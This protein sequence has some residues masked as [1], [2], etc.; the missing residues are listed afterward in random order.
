MGRSKAAH[1]RV[2]LPPLETR[3]VDWTGDMRDSRK[4]AEG[5]LD[6]LTLP[7][8]MSAVAY[9]PG[10]GY[11]A[12]GT[13]AG[14]VHLF[15]APSVR[16][17]IPLRPPLRVKH[18]LFKSDTYLLVCIDEKDNLSIYDLSRKDPHAAAMQGSSRSMSSSDLPLR[19]AIHSARN[20]VLCAEVTS[21]HSHLFLG[22][23]DGTVEVYDL[24]RLTTAPYRIPNLW[25][26]EEEIL[27][28]S[29]V[30]NA[31]SRLHIPL[32]IDI[33]THPRDLNLLLLCYEGGAVLY[34]LR[35]AS[36]LHSY[37][38]RLLPGA[39]GPCADDPLEV[40]WSERLCPATSMAWHPDGEMFALG[41]ENGVIS[42]WRVK[43]E[44]K[45]IMVRTLDTTDIERPVPPDETP[46]RSLGPREPIFKLTWSGFPAQGWYEYGAQAAS[47]WTGTGAA[48]TKVEGSEAVQTAAGGTVLTVM[49]G[50]AASQSSACLTV[51]HLPPVPTA[52]LFGSSMGETVTRQRQ[53][54]HDALVSEQVAVY[55]TSSTVEDYCLVPK[56]NPHYH[57]TFDPYAV[58][59]MVGADPSLPAIAAQSTHR[60][61]E[62]YSFPPQK[63]TGTYDRLSL[64]LPLSF[65]GRGTVLG[66]RISN[67]PL[68]QY[69]RLTHH[70]A[71][72]AVGSIKASE[73]MG[74]IARP[75][76]KG[77]GPQHALPIARLGRPRILVTWHLDG[78][79]RFHDVS[80]HLLLLGVDDA[81]RGTLLQTPF[82]MPLP[83]LT[84]RVRQCIMHPTMIGTPAL[85]PLQRFPMQ[86]QIAEVHMAWDALECAVELTT[87]HV[88]HMA[89]GGGSFATGA[90]NTSLPQ[91]LE[92]VHI[93]EG[94]SNSTLP[95]FTPMDA[96]SDMSSLGFQRTCI[97]LRS[98]YGYASAS[99][100]GYGQC[101]KRRWSLCYGV[102]WHARHC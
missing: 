62:A 92:G 45:P 87:G 8:E 60:G 52:S 30:P 1:P 3:I 61:L 56:I 64:P 89:L 95:E 76:I 23:A 18:L 49:G 42:F 84:V 50:T 25:W 101:A 12:V 81:R 91:A 63:S 31:P 9:E 40:I 74:G 80:P 69:R 14:T 59:V 99:W 58:V 68:A 33:Q 98:E 10:M 35:D 47:T 43:D 4:Y 2:P 36:A 44:D 51:F 79:V 83:Q 97:N 57:G 77:A 72:D 7:G 22:L 71:H 102:Q 96:I 54:L 70:A 34:S 48:D 26:N 85:A 16:L 32:I 37:Q 29:N 73:P 21:G 82:P 88:L 41:H 19:V 67:V 94:V 17:V 100:A 75:H 15:G 78:T 38:L 28:R 39:P 20:T 13:T 24:E 65:A 11:L 55:K 86:M 90:A 27:R 46:Q 53:E 93:G 6:Q 66:C 5:L